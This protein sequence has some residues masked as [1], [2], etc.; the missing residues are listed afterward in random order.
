MPTA[1]PCL[2]A[3]LSVFRTRDDAVHQATLLPFLG[4]MV[5]SAELHPEHGKVKL[6]PG[7]V[8]SHSTWWPYPGIDRPALFQTGEV[9]P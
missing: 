1:P 7:K 4:K 8:T 3:G 6:T 2:R 5:A 9:S